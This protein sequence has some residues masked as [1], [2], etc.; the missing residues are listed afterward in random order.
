MEESRCPDCREVIGGRDHHL[1]KGNQHAGEFDQSSR[2]AW[3]PQ[4]FD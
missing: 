2:P 3:D 1:A 4:G